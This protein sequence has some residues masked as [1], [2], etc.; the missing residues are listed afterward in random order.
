MQGAARGKVYLI[1]L[2]AGRAGNLDAG[3]DIKPGLGSLGFA[4]ER[5]SHVV[6]AQ[7]ATKIQYDFQ[8]QHEGEPRRLGAIGT[9]TICSEDLP[10]ADWRSRG[11]PGPRVRPVGA[12]SSQPPSFFAPYLDRACLRSATPCESS[13]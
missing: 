13:T 7:A 9:T 12:G 5:D 1:V 6:S 10:S 4:F 2:V 8:F 3:Q 11:L